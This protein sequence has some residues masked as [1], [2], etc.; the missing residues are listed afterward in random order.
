VVLAV[1]AFLLVLLVPREAPSG[2]ISTQ[3]PAV[4]DSGV[5]GTPTTTVVPTGVPVV[6]VRLPAGGSATLLR[7][8]LTSDGALPIPEK[9]DQATWW[10]AQ[11]GAE[12][13]ATLLAGHVSWKGQPG[14]F[15]ELWRDQAG[16]QVTVVDSQ[17]RDWVYRITELVTV[18]KN[19]LPQHAEQLYGQ[20]GKHRLVLATCG[21]D[22]VGGTEGYADNRFAIAELVTRS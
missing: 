3:H 18:H 16:Q 4:V 15:E 14:P 21:G 1:T 17:G 13:G 6:A 7:A 9:L 22:F 8:N 11:F 19:D 12:H 20:R 2:A 10:G 5:H